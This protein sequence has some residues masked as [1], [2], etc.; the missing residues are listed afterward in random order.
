MI[1]RAPALPPGGTLGIVA[2]SSW[3]KARNLRRGVA[4]LRGF[5]YRVKLFCSFRWKDGYLAGRD[6]VRA[7]ALNRA[8]QD[9]G[10][11]AVVCARGGYGVLRIVDRV[12]FAAIRRRPRIIVGF[13]DIT[14]LELAIWKH[15][16]LVTFYGPMAA[17]RSPPY[18]WRW[19]R[20]VLAARTPVGPVPL[21]AGHRPRF[22]RPGRATGRILGGTLS[23]VSKLVG[24]PHLPDLD[25]AILF[26]EDVDERPYKIDGYLAHLR[27]AGVLDRVG[28]VVLANFKKCRPRGR[29]SLGLDRIFRDYFGKAR[30]PVAIGFPFG[31]EDPM[32]TLPQG[33]R[34]T[35]DSRRGNMILREPGVR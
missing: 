29:S 18:N 8:L 34:A 25:G 9:P 22:I 35:L 17:F 32:F 28:G 21:P 12:D 27:L 14:V 7:A 3:A 6:A 19:W 5:G 2:P 4:T 33:V 10:V 20:H 26:L 23:L 15:C 24:T 31:H 30:Y 11:D 13:S 1:L 16:R